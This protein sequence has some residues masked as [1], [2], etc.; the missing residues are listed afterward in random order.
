MIDSH[1]RYHYTNEE[2]IIKKSLFPYQESNLGLLSESGM[3]TT[4]P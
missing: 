4:T 1:V 2:L 3:L